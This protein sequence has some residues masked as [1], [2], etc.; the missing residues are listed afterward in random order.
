MGDDTNTKE[1]NDWTANEIKETLQSLNTTVGTMNKTLEII[2][3]KDN[4]IQESKEYRKFKLACV[5][6]TIAFIFIAY[7]IIYFTAMHD[8]MV[9]F[10]NKL[11]K[12]ERM[13]E[14]G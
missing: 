8:D 4:I 3:K 6:A 10:N 9:K 2:N 5:C 13:I 1:K 7:Y 12:I 11:T 14:N